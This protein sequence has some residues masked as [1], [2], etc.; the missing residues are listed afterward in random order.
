MVL[1]FCHALARYISSFFLWI[2]YFSLFF[3]YTLWFINIYIEPAGIITLLTFWWLILVRA[4]YLRGAGHCIQISWPWRHGRRVTYYDQ[5]S[6]CRWK[7]NH[8]IWG[9]LK[10]NGKEN[11]GNAIYIYIYTY[12]GQ[13]FKPCPCRRKVPHMFWK[14]FVGKW[15]WWGTEGGLQSIRQGSRWLHFT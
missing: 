13:F 4:H 15:C 14:T 1:L 11:Q 10:S 7:W 12:G 3:L 5:G 8:R 6:W 9:V 2:C